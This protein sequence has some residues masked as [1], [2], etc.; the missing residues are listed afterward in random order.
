MNSFTFFN[1]TK[2]I[3]GAGEVNKLGV[4]ASQYGKKAL[5]IKTTGPIQKSGIFERTTKILTDAG[6]EVFYLDDVTPNPKFTK[7]NEGAEICREKGIDIVIGV[8]GGTAIDLAKG[9]AWAALAE[10]NLWDYFLRK[11][12]AT[13]S[14]PIGAVTT[15]V[16]TGAEMNV[17]CTITNQDTKEKFGVHFPVSFPK[18]AIIDPELQSN[19][20]TKLTAGGMADTISHVLETYFDGTEDTPLQDRISEGII[21]TVI[22]NERILKN[23]TDIAARGNI[24]WAATLAING[25]NDSGRGGKDWDAHTIEHEVSA[26]YDVR[27][28]EGMAVV[29]IAWMYHLCKENPKKFVHFA[30]RIFGIKKAPGESD[31]SVGTKGIDALKAKFQEW[32]M[33]TTLRELGVD[34]DIL[35]TLA[36]GACKNPEGSKLNADVVLGVLNSCY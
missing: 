16:G 22:E 10:G 4:E 24:C 28:G 36:N 2:V 30:D 26:K 12:V 27:H 19:L 32:G 6:M 23:P 31:L 1:P 14:L 29:H 21:F 35:P 11:R 15:I 3:F 7:L 18:F 20:P 13:K 34:K 17:N 33:P 9:V 25:I 5:M 8:G